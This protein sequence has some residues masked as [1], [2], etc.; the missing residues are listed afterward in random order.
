MKLTQRAVDTLTLPAARSEMIAFDDDLPG[1]GLRLRTAGG[2]TWVYQYKLGA[3]QRRI[4]LGNAS[5]IRLDHARATAS[6]LHAQVRLGFDPA[7]ERAE[8]RIAAAETLEAALRLYLPRQKTRVRWRSYVE[9]ERYLNRYFRS[10]HEWPLTRVDRR[11]VAEA[12][13]KIEVEHGPAAANRARTTLTA[14]Y[15][16]CITE[17]ITD[18]NP[19]TGTARRE[20]AARSRVLS[21]DELLIVWRT[22]GD[23]QFSAIVRL[24]ILT[25]QRR[26]EIGG[27][28]WCEID[29]DAGVIRLPAERVKNK[30]SHSVPLPAPARA[31]LEAQ[32]QGEGREFV[33]GRGQG[34][35]SGWSR[36]KTRLDLRIA[37]MTGHPLPGWTLHDL[38]RSVVTGMAEIGTQPHV[39]E[40][41][42]NHVSGHKAGVA[43]IYNRSAY[44]RE[45]RVALQTWTEHLLALVEK[46][47]S[48]IVTL[49]A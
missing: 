28:M 20:E 12:L 42:I 30:R 49:R 27:L 38:R 10:L 2:R 43:G 41:V 44:E 4:T 7:A 14:F 17:G 8:R 25:A 35:F 39:I 33:F 18:H 46:R 32:P 15:S 40:A 19:V 37:E 45:K 13:A 22:L 24:L 36:S 5:A 9:I 48:K 16:W 21:E 11:A 34:G 23:D 6:K 3:K 1:L 31:V 29:L 26:E 47:E